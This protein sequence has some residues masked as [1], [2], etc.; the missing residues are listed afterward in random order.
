M[1]CHHVVESRKRRVERLQSLVG[2]TGLLKGLDDDPVAG[3]A[4]TNQTTAW[5]SFFDPLTGRTG[6]LRTTAYGTPIPSGGTG[7]LNGL[8]EVASVV[9]EPGSMLLL[10][11]GLAGMLFAARRR[12]RKDVLPA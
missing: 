1:H 2:R 8:I 6:Q 10:G 7:D 11:T 3:P 5:Q 12:G 4:N 9:P